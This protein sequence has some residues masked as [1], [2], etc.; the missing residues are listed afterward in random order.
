MESIETVKP[1]KW[2]AAYQFVA[3]H[4]ASFFIAFAWAMRELHTVHGLRG[5]WNFILT[6]NSN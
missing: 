2:E 3:A 5:L 1:S 4:K 6:G